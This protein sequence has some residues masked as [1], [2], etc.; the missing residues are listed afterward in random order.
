[1][2]TDVGLRYLLG[3]AELIE[4]RIRTL[5][6]Q[7]RT[8]DPA[9]DDPFRGLYIGEDVVER[10][11]E[12]AVS[13][14]SWAPSPRRNQLE[15]EADRDEAAGSRIRLRDLARRVP[16][17]SEDVELLLICLLPDLDTRFERLYGYLNDDVTRRRA[18]VGLALT[19]AGL[20]P[21]VSSARAR[22]LP[23]S[24]LIEHALVLVED[25]D[26]PY[27]TRGLRVPDRVTAHLLGDDVVES[28]IAD[29]LIDVPAYESAQAHELGVY[30]RRGLRFTYLRERLG[31]AGAELALA[32]LAA[33][34]MG[35]VCVDANRVAAHSDPSGVVPLLGREALL[36][37]AGLVLVGVDALSS[38]PG[39]LRE[40]AALPVPVLMVGSSTWDPEWADV[41]PLVVEVEPPTLSQRA[42]LWSRATEGFGVDVGEV[43]AQF[44]LGPRQVD[45]AVQAARA[46]AMIT[47]T[48]LTTSLLRG[49]ARAQNT[50]G[51]ERAARRIEPAVGWQDIV[52]PD[53]A[54]RQLHELSARARHRYR[55]LAEWKMRPGG[56]RGLGVTALFAGDS[57]TGKTMAAEVIALDLGL[58]LYT[59][60]LAAVVSKYI[61]ETEK[62]L[63]R[64][65]SEAD[66][67][68]AVLL[69]DEADAIFGK[70]SEVRDA[71]DRY[72]NIESAYLLQRMESFDGLAIL[73]TN[74]RAN[75]DEAF[76]RR[77]DIIVDF[78]E[79]DVDARRRLWDRC[80]RP[81][82]PCGDDLDLQYCAEAFV[83]TGGNIRSASISAAYAAAE[84]GRSVSMTDVIAAVQQEYRKLGR[85]VMDREFVDRSQNAVREGQLRV[86]H[87]PT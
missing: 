33:V 38:R 32:A 44:V 87:S 20:S 84:A 24:P 79:P 62:N 80:L 75:L 28:G 66:G 48:P 35:C 72:A 42:A 67:V 71:H 36:G 51:L 23:G 59:V 18:T 2:S 50:S 52:L 5:I 65:F 34:D 76:T 86:D 68:N 78:P 16:L 25:T 11:L 85:L 55:V 10:L 6:T 30:L 27:L 29:L 4:E 39:T 26:R 14:P 9:P 22:L 74:L 61:G 31:R 83:L 12:G 82:L 77:L 1:M 13:P 53:H 69:F 73:A 81:P 63:E 41:L 3:R 49:G 17:S 45:R 47:D 40:A 37:G 7:R 15:C 70:R 57:G 56:G 21:L 43:S 46:T 60:D 8:V 58:D 54:L 19:L 64:I